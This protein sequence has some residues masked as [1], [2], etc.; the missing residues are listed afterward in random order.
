WW[1]EPLRRGARA[2][3]QPWGRRSAVQDAVFSTMCFTIRVV[4]AWWSCW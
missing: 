1:K 4:H 2:H 3:A